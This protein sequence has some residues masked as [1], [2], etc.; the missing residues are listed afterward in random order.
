MVQPGF[1]VLHPAVLPPLPAGTYTLHG[2]VEDVP[3]GPVAPLDSAITVSSP[4]WTMPPDQILSTFPP[5]NS[6]GAYR[7]TLPQIVLKR[8]TLPWE[9]KVDANERIP[10]LALVVIAE[11]EGS[12]SAESPVEQCVTDFTKVPQPADRDVATSVYLSVTQTVVNGVFPCKEDL[13]LLA[14]VR[15]VDLSDSEL[16]DGDDDG[17]LA[18]VVANRLPQPGFDPKAGHIPRKYLACLVNLETQLPV[19]PPPT[20]DETLVFEFDSQALVQDL[21]PLAQ[22]YVANPDAFAMGASTSA[23]FAAQRDVRDRAAR[24][25]DVTGAYVGAAESVETV[26][27]A[28]HTASSWSPSPA[29]IEQAAVSYAA[30][31][32]AKL[33]RDAM[34]GSWRLPVG[35]I[36]FEPVYR[37]PVLAHWSFTVTADGTFEQYMQNLDVGLLGTLHGDKPAQPAPTTTA[38]PP[39]DAR[40]APELAETG[41]VGLDHLTRRGDQ[42]R[43]WFRGPAAPHPTVREQ[44]PASGPQQGRLPFAHTSDQ[45]RVVVP[46]GREDVSYAAAYEIGRL[47]ALSQSAV[48]SAL[49]RWRQEQFGAER[50]A[51]LAALAAHPAGFLDD[52][53]FEHRNPGLGALVGRHIVLG[54]AGKADAVFA[55]S[56]PLADPGRPLDFLDGNL[57][58]VIAA[59]L[60]LDFEALQQKAERLSIVGALV[61]TAVPV[62]AQPDPAL[63]GPAF[64]GLQADLDRQVGALVAQSGRIRGAAADALDN[65]LAASEE[66]Q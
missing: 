2:E 27:H 6:E 62:G 53:L 23:P 48:V 19:L 59:G 10:W 64:S 52:T 54:A 51:L 36:T 41:H 26:S 38:G 42:V 39:P 46:D 40:P 63:G 32:A 28:V 5:A 61:S 24:P 43:A 45:L 14:H 50:A 35:A 18:V 44:A 11:G 33:V 16:A 3:V 7:A 1:F 17:F 37:F 30:S 12:L 8:R 34:A 60:G 57:D 55:S 9:R 66:R 47:L 25:A 22:Q 4:R 49:M 21:R 58:Q 31:D 20:P 65:L 15:E 13:E 29:Q 56:R